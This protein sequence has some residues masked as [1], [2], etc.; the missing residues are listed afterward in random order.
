[1]APRRRH[2]GFTARWTSAIP[3]LRAGPEELIIPSGP[4][5]CDLKKSH[6]DEKILGRYCRHMSL[7]DCLK[8]NDSW[9]KTPENDEN[10]WISEKKNK[11]RN[12]KQQTISDFGT[13]TTSSMTCITWA[14][15]QLMA[16]DG[17]W[18]YL[19]IWN[20]LVFVFVELKPRLYL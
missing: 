12:K 5:G 16:I 19:A 8:F 4:S 10:L 13:L 20:S 15:Q 11:G 6:E 18:W 17:H 1:M 3:D 7:Y 14:W 9:K 2:S